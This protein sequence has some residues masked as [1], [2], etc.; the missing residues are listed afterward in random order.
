MKEPTIRAAQPQLEEYARVAE[1][2][3]PPKS[4]TGQKGGGASPARDS[5]KGRSRRGV[6]VNVDVT[7]F[8]VEYACEVPVPAEFRPAE[9]TALTLDCIQRVSFDKVS[10]LRV[11]LAY[12]EKS[13]CA[14]QVEEV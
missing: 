8:Q 14:L 3:Q 7:S 1:I 9:D 10:L 5:R 12:Q 13:T 4:L 11:S 6:A 2:C